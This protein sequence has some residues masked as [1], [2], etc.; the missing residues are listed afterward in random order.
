M[1]WKKDFWTDQCNEMYPLFSFAEP[2]YV[3]MWKNRELATLEHVNY[4]NEKLDL[5]LNHL[6]LEYVPESTK[7]E[8]AKLVEKPQISGI[9]HFQTWINDMASCGMD[10][11]KKKRGRPKKK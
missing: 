11:K 1:F 9:A 8:P 2:Y 6:N 3:P 4:V 10:T 7:N 5:I